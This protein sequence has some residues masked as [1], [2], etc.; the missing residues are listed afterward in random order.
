[1]WI[2]R[3]YSDRSGRLIGMDS[4]RRTFPNAA[5][6]F[7]AIR[8]ETCRTPWCD[9]P[10]R[11][12]DHVEPAA[13]GGPTDIANGQGPC[14]NCNYIRAAAGWSG[15]TEVDGTVHLVTPTGSQHTRAPRR[16]HRAQAVIDVIHPGGYVPVVGYLAA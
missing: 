12:I 9:A 10:I 15:G 5:R 1:V 13:R 6:R 4:R 3:L 16:H 7:I 8:D 2:R 14:E 11:Q